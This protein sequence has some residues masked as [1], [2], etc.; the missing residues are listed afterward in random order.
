MRK[1]MFY[2]SATAGFPD[3]YVL[4][5]TRR[6][7]QLQIGNSVPPPLAEKVAAAIRLQVDGYVAPTGRL[8]M[9]AALP[10]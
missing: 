5:G 3:D 7:I 10:I 2:S 4:A 9:Q 6:D 1:Q 8:L